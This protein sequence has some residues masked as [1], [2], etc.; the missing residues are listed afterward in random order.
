[1]RNIPAP[2]LAHLQ[3]SVTTTCRLLKITLREGV[4]L[5]GDTSSPAQRSF[6]FATLDQPVTYD[7]GDGPIEYSATNGFDPSAFAS[8]ST[9]AI[10]NAEGYALISDDVD[11]G[12]SIADIERGVLDD[13]QWRCY[14]VNF[15][16][17]SMG[18]VLLDAGDVG[19]VRTRYGMVWMPQLLS[20]VVRL[21]QPIGSVDSR[22]CRAKF[23]TPPNTQTGCGVN[24]EVLWV[25]GTVTAVGAEPDAMFTGDVTTTSP[26]DPFPGRVEWLT[27]DNVG[28]QY[29][30]DSF[31]AGV[32]R[33]GEPTP[34]PIQVGDL[35]RIRPDCRK[36]YTEDCIG[37]WN[38]GL[39]FKGE[40][41]IPVGDATSGQTPGAQLPGGGGYTGRTYT[42]G[43]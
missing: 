6:G 14:L 29:W 5:E 39:N 1:M 20:Y 24:A 26:V 34:F 17:L 28:R 38:N 8:E 15:E 22:T 19:P 23:G 27:G 4:R 37:V 16:D 40:P 42:R 13:A 2:L 35:Y 43:D 36:R 7:D 32:V 30:T 21:R 10:A 11:L 3:Q 33:L 18:H 25:A 12:I 31:E 9:Y 41:L